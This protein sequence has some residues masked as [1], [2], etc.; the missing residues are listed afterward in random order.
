[1]HIKQTSVQV[2][3][4]K[5]T[6]SVWIE[7]S[8]AELNTVQS[9][10]YHLHPTFVN[11]TV[12]RSNREDKFRL[13]AGGW[14]TFVLRA[15]LH[16]KG[17]STDSMRHRLRFSRS[18]PKT[19]VS[20]ASTDEAAID[21]VKEAVKGMFIGVTSAQDVSPEDDLSSSI[22]E[23]ID[24][25]KALILI[26]GS[27]PSRWVMQE[28]ETAKELGKPIISVGQNAFYDTS[29]ALKINSLGE[30]EGVISKLPE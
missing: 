21:D 30:L 7:G 11:P 22:R 14:G 4:S 2:S 3:E 10:T 23:Q 16:K 19:F 24:H 15:E 27:L 5:W 9:V 8:D 20:A 29:D 17:G 28:I 12:E 18:E 1:M 6:W 13:D 26:N 25:A